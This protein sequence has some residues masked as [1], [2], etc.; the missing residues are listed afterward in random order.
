MLKKNKMEASHFL[1]SKLTTELQSSK[2]CGTDRHIDQ[3]T[4]IESPEINPHVYG[5]KTFTKIAKTVQGEKGSLF[6]RKQTYDYQ[7]GKG[8]GKG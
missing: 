4:R 7:K 8:V 2:Y 1:T 6:H 3:H 5:P